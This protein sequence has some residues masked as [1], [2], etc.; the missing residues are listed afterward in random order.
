MCRNAP[1]EVAHPRRQP[2]VH[3]AQWGGQEEAEA[4]TGC[5][6]PAAAGA[7]VLGRPATAIS[8]AVI[9]QGGDGAVLCARGAAAPIHISALQVPA[10]YHSPG[11]Q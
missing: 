4:V 1:F 2:A 3:R 5:S 11:V 7:W 6:D 10:S 8:W 9:K